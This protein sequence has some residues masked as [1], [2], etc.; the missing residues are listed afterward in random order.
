M[1]LRIKSHWSDPDRA[2]SLDEVAGALAFIAWRIALDRA[3]N[4]HC[5]R[6][7]Y[8]DDAQRLAVIEEYLVFLIQIADRLAHARLDEDRRRDLITGFARRVFDHV[9]DNATDLLGPGAHGA[10]FIERLNAR[11]GEYAEY[12]FTDEGPSYALLRHLGFEIQRLM[13]EG[14]ENRWVI[15]QVMDQDGWEAYRRFDRAF[16]DLFESDPV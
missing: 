8:R 1:A 16:A 5:E 3:I 7:V 11:S 14:Q 12:G 4:L 9:Q 15:D 2:R 6:F 10:A 13:G